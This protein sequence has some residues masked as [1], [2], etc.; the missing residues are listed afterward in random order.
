MFVFF[1]ERPFPTPIARFIA[2]IANEP[3]T[4]V[5]MAVTGH[6]SLRTEQANLRLFGSP[7]SGVYGET[8]CIRR[9]HVLDG[10]TPAWRTNGSA[11]ASDLSRS[12]PIRGVGYV[13]VRVLAAWHKS[14]PPPPAKLPARKWR[15]LIRQAWHTDSL[16][17]PQC[18]QEMRLIAV[19][20]QAEVVEK[21]LRHLH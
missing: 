1:S 21:I 9:S 3:A 13:G 18:Q 14:S 15:D 2:I 12:A 16:E 4:G 20:D 6:P 8:S 19:T 11:K 7:V 17:Y 5:G 10:P